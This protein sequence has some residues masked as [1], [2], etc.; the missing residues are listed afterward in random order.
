M[1]L[2]YIKYG[3]LFFCLLSL[4]GCSIDQSNQKYDSTQP[5]VL[6]L[7]QWD[8][9]SNRKIALYGKWEFYWNQLLDSS[10]F[11]GLITPEPDLL[12]EVPEVWN[13]YVINGE[14]LPAYGFA[15]YRLKVI[16]NEKPDRLALQLE[17]FSTSARIFVDGSLIYESGLVSEHPDKAEPDFNPGIIYIPSQK[18][19]L[20]FIVQISNYHHAKGG[21]WGT[22]YLGK[23]DFLKK[24][25]D[26]YTYFEVFLIATICITGLF[27]IAV[28]FIRRQEKAALF[29]GLMCILVTLRLTSSNTY[30]VNNFLDIHWVWLFKIEYISYFLS[31]SFFASYVRALYLKDFPGWILRF[32]WFFSGAYSLFFLFTPTAFFTR[33]ITG[34]Q[35]FTILLCLFITYVI[36]RAAIFNRQGAL[37]FLLVWVSLFITVLNDILFSLII[38]RSFN[39]VEF[40]IFIFVLAQSVFLAQRF[41]QVLFQSDTLNLELQKAN[42]TLEAKVNERKIELGQTYVELT[43]ISKNLDRVNHKVTGN[44][45]YAQRIQ[46]SILPEMK[47]LRKYF[48]ALF[49]YY[50]PKDL[51]SGDFYWFGIEKGKIILV[52][53]DCTGH[54]V[55]G[56]LMTMV[57]HDLLNQIVHFEHITQPNLI[58]NAMH[59]KFRAT[60]RQGIHSNREGIDIALVVIDSD[61]T[62]LQFAGAKRPLYYI[63]K[64]KLNHID[65]DKLS[66][67]GIHPQEY[68]DYT[69][70]TMDINTLTSFYIFSDGFADQL[71]GKSGKKFLRKRF[72]K[73]LLDNSHLPLHK[74]EVNFKKILENWRNSPYDKLPKIKG[75]IEQT[76]DILVIGFKL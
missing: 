76:D 15:T 11:N 34:Y 8:G 24:Q 32:I 52:A 58:L 59:T 3:L 21:F 62:R 33:F 1:R 5:G 13:R 40:G 37:L 20:E 36:I 55:P 29:F 53:G 26:L 18:T 72:Q 73:L 43:K 57:A 14:N 2:I 51:I 27:N 6:I 9:K 63:E 47:L 10:D 67:G 35:V 39:T 31:S 25:Y 45:L 28:F 60:L 46:A 66:I 69:C 75:L 56:A 19:E 17:T 71:G 50:S 30:L 49:I 70:H 41:A 12:V 61:Y 42:E 48:P 22:L 68:R 54:G 44:I 38:I 23:A 65:G 64:Q 4:L 7:S 16:L 74:Q